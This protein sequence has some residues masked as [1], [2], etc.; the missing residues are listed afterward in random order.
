MRKLLVLTWFLFGTTTIF[1][2][3]VTDQED[4][5]L[6]LKEQSV[7]SEE[8][9][10]EP[11]MPKSFTLDPMQEES[12]GSQEVEQTITPV[13]QEANQK[14]EPVEEAVVAEP[15][16]QNYT[17]S[18]KSKNDD[19]QTLAGRNHHSG[20]FGA[21]SF[22]ATNFN[23]KNIVMAGFR[24]GWIINRSFAIGL[25]AY[26]VIPTAEYGGID[27][28]FNT[29]AV[30]G[31][32]GLFLEPIVL[33][34]KII[35]IT[36]P[37]SGGAGWMGYLYDWEDIGYNYDGEVVDGDVFWYIEPGAALELNVARNFRINF[38]ASYRFTQDLQLLNTPDTAFDDWNYFLTLKFGKF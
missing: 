5:N 15:S 14:I 3:S 26:G 33:S 7:Y 30:G 22:K 18:K 6:E 8:E 2:Q 35:H 38:G 21:I 12:T 29:R 24:A 20:G 16:T 25:D 36:F 28:I 23:D 27:P 10:E 19:I 37:V 31:Y 9:K 4:K 1:S 17:E 11:T 34:N 32:G 13:V